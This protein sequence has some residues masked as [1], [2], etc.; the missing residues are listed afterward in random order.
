MGFSK[1]LPA[2]V[3]L[4]STCNA[5]AAQTP[6]RTDASSVESRNGLFA[7]LLESTII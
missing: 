5:L 6:A 2:I 7:P 1:L 3:L 4:V